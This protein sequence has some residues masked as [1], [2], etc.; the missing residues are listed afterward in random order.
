[1]GVVVLMSLVQRIKSYLPASRGRVDELESSNVV[2]R[3]RLNAAKGIASGVEIGSLGSFEY[4]Y[5][6]LLKGTKRWATLDEM[7]SDPHIKG[8]LRANTLPLQ[9]ATWRYSP[10]SDKPR[11]KEVAAFCDANLL[12]IS[13]DQFGREYWCQTSWAAQRLPE[14]L[15]FLSHGF[16][17]FHKSVR[18]VGTKRVFDR[19]QWIEPSTISGSQPWKLDEFD[20]ILGV[21]RTYSTPTQQFRYDDFIPAEQ[22]ALYVWDLK[23]ARYE[24]RSFIRSAYGAYFRK[25]IVQKARTIWAQ[26]AGAP[27]PIGSY[28]DHWKPVQ[29]A[30]FE[31]AVK[32]ARGSSMAEGF[33]IGPIASDGKTKAT[34]EFAGADLDVERGMTQLT[35]AENQEIS[36]A[37]ATGSEMLGETK[38]GSRAVG[39]T[40]QG[41]ESQQIEAVAQIVAEIEMHGVANL[42][43]LRDELV[44]MNYSGVQDLPELTFSGIRPNEELE[45][46][47]QTV[48][49]WTAGI[50]PHHPDARKQ[51]VEKLGIELPDEVYELEKEPP[52]LPT[53]QTETVPD[54][55]DPT[56]TAQDTASIAAAAHSSLDDFRARIAPL[57]EPSRGGAP[58]SGGRFPDRAGAAIRRAGARAGDVSGRG[59]GRARG[60]A[61]GT[62]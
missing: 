43:G 19:L 55:S 61:G 33:F 9:R 15:Q 8:A 25:N 34:I 57:L 24:G 59:Q 53:T 41:R 22:L 37:A 36:H 58:T 3:H 27:I 20:N 17:A 23:G 18:V 62:N 46:F 6:Q 14:I 10:A 26:K 40:Q 52:P 56:S 13:S 48:A 30:A 38:T 54:S 4:E 28:P 16:S 1:M 60:A 51:I 32:A 49:A 11:D 35:D 44:G 50:I 47:D 2:L 45:G 7:E 31:V 42:H 21:N 39:Q 29:I 12:R 5:N